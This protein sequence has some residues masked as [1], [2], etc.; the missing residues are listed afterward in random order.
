[1]I[2][3]S[4]TPVTVAVMPARIGPRKPVRVY[5]AA[6]RNHLG[7][8]QQQVGDRIGGGVDK[9]TISRWENAKRTPSLNVLA[10]YAEALQIPVENLYR[11]P[12]EEPSLDAMLQGAS[13][14][15]RDKVVEVAK[16]LLKTGTEP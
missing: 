5:L 12:N 1:M 13:K 8:T 7:L 11:P 9:A 14:D 15:V 3:F 16:I 6:W 4:T 2:T 10:A